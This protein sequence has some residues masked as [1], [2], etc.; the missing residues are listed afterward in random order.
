[1][2]QHF[3]ALVRTLIDPESD[4]LGGEKTH[5]E[6]SHSLSRERPLLA[7]S[8]FGSP[9][10]LLASDGFSGGFLFEHFNE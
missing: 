1:M 10:R 2:C 4:N 6:M 5:C 9:L 7:I 3:F 8:A